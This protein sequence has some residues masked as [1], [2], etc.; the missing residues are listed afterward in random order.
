MPIAGSLKKI[1]CEV[2]IMVVNGQDE[3][4]THHRERSF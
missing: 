4:L 1:C 3:R 2:L